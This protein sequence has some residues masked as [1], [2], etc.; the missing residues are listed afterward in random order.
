MMAH[1][2]RPKQLRTLLL[3][4]VLVPLIPAALMVRFMLDTLKGERFAALDRLQQLHT[5]TLISALRYPP[6]AE[7]APDVEK[8]E[9]LLRQLRL[10]SMEGI[11]ARVIDS[12]GK[13]IAGEAV[14]WGQP[15]AE[16]A[17]TFLPNASVQLF[18]EGP[19]VLDGAISGQRRILVWTAVLT[20][21][22]VVA[23]AGASA[24]ALNRQIT[25]RD[26][27]NTSVATVAHE[28]R[29]PLASM[30]MLVDTLL[31]GRYRGDDQMREYLELIAAENDRLSR[32]AESFLTFS[33]VNQGRKALKLA[34]I[35]PE[36]VAGQSIAALRSRLDA[37]GC[38]FTFHVQPALPDIMADPDALGQVL[39]NL[40][41]N[42]LKYTGDQKVISLNLS[43]VGNRVAFAVS[44]NGIGIAE[45]DRATI[46]T[47][48]YQVDQKLSRSREGCGLGLAIVRRIVEAHGG[49]LELSS[50]VG[51]GTTFT[52]KIPVA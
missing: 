35:K 26:L 18:L 16:A 11:T 10:L 36:S 19:E 22:A 8:A 44:D 31:E 30:R 48:F 9:A 5:E 17:P 50:K 21:V 29:T 49:T 27:R 1:E 37:P 13:L 45:E 7:S 47:P 2:I 34:A 40:L 14:P 6:A 3:L 12:Q 39:S 24:F 15:L 28:L 42:A 25:L 32:L 33:R 43:R 46:F 23:I 52:A 41:D 20:I 4:L 51:K 38:T